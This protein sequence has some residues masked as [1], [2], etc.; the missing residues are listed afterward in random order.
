MDIIEFLKTIYV[1]DRGCKSILVDGW[2]SEVKVMVT[3]ISRVR[4]ATWDYYTDED[5]PDGYIVFEGV[6]SITFEPSGIIP[7]DYINYIRAESL[8]DD[9]SKYMIV[10]SIDGIDSIGNHAEVKIRIRAD[11]MALE[12]S[13]TPGKR[14]TR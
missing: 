10:I 14:I 1:G 6:K 9:Q 2:N 11:S 4:S 7:N 8:V 5:L 3:C 12:D 13:N